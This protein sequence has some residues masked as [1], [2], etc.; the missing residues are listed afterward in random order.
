[1]TNI[2]YG[3]GELLGDAIA[4]KNMKISSIPKTMLTQIRVCCWNELCMRLKTR[5]NNQE[6]CDLAEL[7]E[8]NRVDKAESALGAP[9]C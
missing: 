1:M 5:L 8:W 6:S 4:F 7:A 2:R 9:S 3:Q